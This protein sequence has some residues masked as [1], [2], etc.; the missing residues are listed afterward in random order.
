VRII[1]RGE[2][3]YADGFTRLISGGADSSVKLWDLQ[4]LEPTPRVQ[5]LTPKGAVARFA[6]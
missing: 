4:D 5:V 1:L 2:S 6:I 3:D